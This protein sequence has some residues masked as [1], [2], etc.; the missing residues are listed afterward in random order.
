[1]SAFCAE[2]TFRDHHAGVRLKDRI[3][4]TAGRVSLSHFS[5]R[6]LLLLGLS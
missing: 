2:V 3:K 5:M 6:F 4:Q 1:M